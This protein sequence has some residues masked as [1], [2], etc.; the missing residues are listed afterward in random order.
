MYKINE[1]CQHNFFC[2]FKIKLQKSKYVLIK[3][4]LYKNIHQQLKQ[5]LIHGIKK[6]K[7]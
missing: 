3:K 4:Y 7:I 2:L 1:K 6:K 5:K